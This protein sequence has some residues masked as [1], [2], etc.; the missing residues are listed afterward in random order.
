MRKSS[1]KVSSLNEAVANYLHDGDSVSFSGMGGQ[2]CVASAFE[3]VRQGKKQLT[4]IGDS[5]CEVADVLIGAGAIKKAEVAWI[6][7]AVAGIAANYR[8]AVEEGVPHPIEVA[9]VSNYTAGLRFLAGAMNIPFLPTKSLLGSD[10]PKYNPNIKIIDDPY[11]GEPVALIPAAHPDVAFIHVHK[12]DT[13]GN[14]QVFGWSANAENIARAAKHTIVTCE[15]II[16]TDE[17]RMRPNCTIIPQF[18]VDAVVCVPYGSHP[19]NMP[20]YYAY[21]IPFHMKMMAE[22]KTRDSFLNWLEEWVFGCK[23]HTEYCRKVGWE[24]LLALTQ[25]ERKFTR[26]W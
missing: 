6:G 18:C 7:Y 1:N 8:R 16:S 14:S 2:Q 26:I 12:A 5:P 10:L 11:A 24:R 15:E 22:F 21:D 13:L 20:Y 25:I 19:W 23:D 9:E 4:I 17:V 3:I